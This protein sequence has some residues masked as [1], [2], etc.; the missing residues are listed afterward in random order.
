MKVEEIISALQE[1]SAEHYTE[2]QI[3]AHQEYPHILL[4]AE[5]SAIESAA[6]L[7][8]LS[9]LTHEEL[10]SAYDLVDKNNLDAGLRGRIEFL[11][12]P[13][14]KEVPQRNESISRLL[15]WFTDKKSGKVV[16][17]RKELKG[18]FY[19]QSYSDQKKIIKAFLESGNASDREWAAIIAD[20][21]WDIA[22][23][24]SL[25]FAWDTKH[26]VTIA[27]TVIRHL[28]TDYIKANISELASLSSVDICIKLG[29]EEGFRLEDFELDFPDYLYATAVLRKPLAET[30]IEVER[31]FFE[32]IYKH[33]SEYGLLYSTSFDNFPKL[34]K[35]IW[36]FGQHKMV[37]TLLRFLELIRYVDYHNLAGPDGYELVKLLTRQ[38]ISE[39][40][41]VCD[42][43]T[44]KGEEEGWPEDIS[45]PS[46][47]H[48]FI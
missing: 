38:W 2:S 5:L 37:Q 31:K 29:R 42:I 16:A 48:E 33:S 9:T 4:R 10:L 11:I 45:Y 20:K 44:D 21:H 19:T 34:R 26:T 14:T 35:M 40:Y 18:R 15:K 30:E 47:G 32:Y 1:N 24:D 25:K 28:E 8:A 17:A 41:E 13:R 27:K 12:A 6:H 23:V 39:R 7:S 36:S 46:F 22:Y 3:Q 43:E